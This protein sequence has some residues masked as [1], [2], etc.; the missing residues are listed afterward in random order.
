M[1]DHEDATH[2]EPLATPA[3][4]GAAF[5]REYFRGTQGGIYLGVI[6]NAGSKLSRGE[7][8]HLIT[9]NAGQIEK[10]LA[11]HD[12]PEHECA[13]Y[14]CTATLRDGLAKRIGTNCQHFPSI[15]SDIDDHN[16]DLDRARVIELLEQ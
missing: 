3:L 16:H 14:Y 6:R 13:L 10:F 11:E 1:L 8:A 7:I 2:T 15:F 5:I 9:R 4:T 12:K